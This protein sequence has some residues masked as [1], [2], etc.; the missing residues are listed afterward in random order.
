[1]SNTQP[2]HLH[3]VQHSLAQPRFSSGLWFNH[4]AKQAL[5][6][7]GVLALSA[8][9]SPMGPIPG[10]KLEGQSAAWPDDWT[11]TD[12]IEN[13]LLETDPLDPYSVTIW[14][15]NVDN[16]IYVAA[17]SQESRWVQN[18]DANNAVILGIQQWLYKAYAMRIPTGE[19]PDEVGQAYVAKYERDPDD[20]FIENG[21]I[22]FELTERP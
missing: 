19:I 9:S 11:F 4:W 1:M 5:V 6:T 17:T 16:R 10:G 20:N 15:V 13:V 12:S 14:C 7:L 2:I 21:G 8:C 18:I 3:T 22:I